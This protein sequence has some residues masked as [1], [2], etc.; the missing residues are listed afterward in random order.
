MPDANGKLQAGDA[1]YV[2]PGQG[3]INSTPGQTDVTPAAPVTGY[4]PA[5][6]PSTPTPAAQGYAPTPYTVPKEGSVQE[7]VKKIVGEDSPL[8]QQARQTATQQMHQRGL[9]N[10]S[11]AVSAGEQG[12]INSALPIAQADAASANTAMTNTANASNAEKNFQAGA[13]NTA[14]S[15]HAQLEN[16]LNISNA[17]SANTAL[18]DT[19]KAANSRMLALIDT[20]TKTTLATLDA[21]N[22]Q[23]L[24][25]NANAASMFQETVKNIAAIA[26]SDKM[27]APTKA[28]AT[29]SQINLLNEGLRTTAAVAATEQA[30]VKNLNLSQFFTNEQGLLG[31]NAEEEAAKKAQA[32]KTAADQA[33][34]NLLEQQHAPGGGYY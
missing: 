25:S 11:I 16:S 5:A 32:D 24:Q 19:A 29:K 1:G 17:N 23:L 6:A 2:P 9:I 10:S 15:V 18:D 20:G 30:A 26:T 33:A 34:A 4:T 14:E 27:D 7:Q 3:L 12:V 13:A 22:R 21:Q 8:I 31:T 28:A